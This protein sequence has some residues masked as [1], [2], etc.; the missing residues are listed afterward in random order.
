[1][2]DETDWVQFGQLTTDTLYDLNIGNLVD[3]S[4]NTFPNKYKLMGLDL[5]I[6]PTLTVKSRQIYGVLYMLGDV[7]GL[8]TCL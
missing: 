8:S 7:G 6:N 1:M 3:S 2:N 4:W 5:L